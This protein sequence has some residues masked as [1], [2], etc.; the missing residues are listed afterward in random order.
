[1][2]LYLEFR[3]TFS[4]TIKGV[5]GCKIN[6]QIQW[7]CC[8]K[9]EISYVLMVAHS[10]QDSE[11]S[12]QRLD[13]RGQPATLWDSRTRRLRQTHHGRG[14]RY[15]NSDRIVY[16]TIL[17]QLP[18]GKLPPDPITIATPNSYPTPAPTPVPTLTPTLPL[19][20]NLTQT[21]PNPKKYLSGN[22]PRDNCP[23]TLQHA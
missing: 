7:L 2:C 16:H 3:I 18:P 23:D 13:S 14:K 20:L 21:L 1:M 15:A 4:M 9:K 11:W 12:F 8:I 22:L 5:A 10:D 19:L 6:K 17:R